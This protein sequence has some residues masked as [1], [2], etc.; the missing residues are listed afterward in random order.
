GF[1]GTNGWAIPE[2][3]S[4]DAADAETAD[5]LYSLLETEVVPLFYDRPDGIPHGWVK[6]MKNSMRV[7]GG[8]FTARRMLEE[9][10]EKYYVPSMMTGATPD[11]PPTF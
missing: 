9:Y 3:S 4:E 1:D 7:A 10:V 2:A 5:N 8:M 6:M 11:N